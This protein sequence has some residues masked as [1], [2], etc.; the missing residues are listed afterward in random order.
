MNTK[1][2]KKIVGA[3]S[4][5]VVGARSTKIVGASSK[6]VGLPPRTRKVINTGGVITEPLLQ[7][8]KAKGNRIRGRSARVSWYETEL[9]IGQPNGGSPKFQGV[10]PKFQEISPKLFHI[11]LQ[12]KLS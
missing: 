9:L 11:S 1:S 10:S 2:S 7:W 4:K 12:I 5:K 6:K 3:R 8:S